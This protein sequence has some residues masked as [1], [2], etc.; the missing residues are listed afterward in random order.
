MSREKYGKKAN[1][2]MFIEAQF[3]SHIL[4][5]HR[6]S[7]QWTNISNIDFL[8]K[9]WC[10][11]LAKYFTI[12]VI[13]FFHSW[14][15]EHLW[16][17]LCPLICPF[18]VKKNVKFENFNSIICLFSLLLLQ[19]LYLVSVCVS[20]SMYGYTTCTISSFLPAFLSWSYNEWTCAYHWYRQHDALFY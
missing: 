5:L 4:L 13:M 9:Y 20:V 2:H 12:L 3:L 1:I 11:S 14:N 17:L 7:P 19:L 6:S 10:N 15:S 8:P 18:F 16:V